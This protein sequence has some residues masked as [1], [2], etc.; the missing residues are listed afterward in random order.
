MI[1]YLKYSCDEK[2]ISIIIYNYIYKIRLIM[3]RV[4][5]ISIIVLKFDKHV[6]P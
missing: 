6:W 2:L 5:I 3:T 4:I 1:R